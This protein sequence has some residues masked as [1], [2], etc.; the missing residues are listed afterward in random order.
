M[1]E[2]LERITSGLV[3]F[4]EDSKFDVRFSFSNTTQLLYVVEPLSQIVT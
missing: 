2:W 4:R 3:Q 1:P